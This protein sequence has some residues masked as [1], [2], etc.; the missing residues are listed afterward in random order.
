MTHIND[1]EAGGTGT[2]QWKSRGRDWCYTLNVGKAAALIVRKIAVSTERTETVKNVNTT[3]HSPSGGDIAY[4]DTD[5]SCQLVD[6]YENGTLMVPAKQYFEA[7]C[8]I[9]KKDPDITVQNIYDESSLLERYA[10]LRKAN[11]WE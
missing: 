9:I 6:G 3:Y 8:E 10:E 4:E 2:E 11:G 7:L 1:R 5:E